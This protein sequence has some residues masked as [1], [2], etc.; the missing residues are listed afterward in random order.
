MA[1]QSPRAVRFARVS[2]VDGRY[3][4]V[5]GWLWRAKNLCQ[6]CNVTRRRAI[7]AAAPPRQSAFFA[8]GWRLL[9]F[10]K[11]AGRQLNLVRNLIGTWRRGGIRSV[12]ILQV[13]VK[14]T[15]SD[16]SQCLCG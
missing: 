14:S 9:V 12:P 4:G 5:F 8:D 15:D 6:G 13:T 1:G 16:S 11:R 2:A 3:G 7:T 10:G